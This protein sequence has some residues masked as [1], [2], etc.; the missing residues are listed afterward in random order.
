[1]DMGELLTRWTVRIALALYVL[2]LLLRRSACGRRSRLAVARLAWSG[3]CLAFLLHVVCAFHFYHDW[4]HAAA[5]ANTARRTADVVGWHW[6][7]GLYANYAF[8]LVW[9]ADVAWWWRGLDGYEERPCAVQWCVR[10]FL[11]CM[12]LNAAVV[13]AEGITRWTSLGVCF[14]LLV[15]R[16]LSPVSKGA[17]P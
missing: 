1:M 5:Y 3:G 6:G 15:F 9:L 14:L 16:L 2:S 17:V 4:S 7:G 13:F 8:M 11:A 12:A 10:G